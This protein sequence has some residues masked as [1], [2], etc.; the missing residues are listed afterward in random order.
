MQLAYTPANVTVKDLGEEAFPDRLATFS[1]TYVNNAN[2][3]TNLILASNKINGTVLMPG[4]TFSYN[5]DSY[6]NRPSSRYL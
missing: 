4:E 1:T 5:T 6:R 3:T 2:R